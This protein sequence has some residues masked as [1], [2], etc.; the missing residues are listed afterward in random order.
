MICKYMTLCAA[1]V[2]HI[3]TVASCHANVTY[4]AFRFG[5]VQVS[6]LL[7]KMSRSKPESRLPA[8]HRTDVHGCVDFSV[9]A[10]EQEVSVCVCTWRHGARPPTRSAGQL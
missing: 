2:Q 8:P 4:V 10:N 5:I 1:Q 9:S 3:V 7:R 6:E